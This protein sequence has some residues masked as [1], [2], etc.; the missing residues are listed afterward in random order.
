MVKENSKSCY[1]VSGLSG[2][3]G[4]ELG[5]LLLD[6][7]HRVIGISRFEPSQKLNY[8]FSKVDWLTFNSSSSEPSL[9]TIDNLER[10]IGDHE[11]RGVFHCSGD[12]HT[13]S[14]LE[15]SSE[16]YLHSI[17]ANLISTVNIVKLTINLINSGGAIVVLNSQAAISSS[18]EEIAYGASKRAVSSYVDSMQFEATKRG[19][20]IINVLCGA[21]RSSMAGGRENYDKFISPSD[22]SEAL[23][24]L[25]LAGESLRFKDVEILRRKY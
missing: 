24:S 13:G 19:L 22:L 4:S 1:I 9:Q 11:L 23:Y 7:G 17:K 10:L 15:V 2:V 8:K 14:P 21:V 25:S 20:Q 16:D 3:I 12:H 18:S 5:G 6:K